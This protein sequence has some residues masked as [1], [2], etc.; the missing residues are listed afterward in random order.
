MP[1][2]CLA[3][4]ATLLVGAAAHAGP[5]IIYQPQN[6]DAT[7]MSTQ[8]QELFGQLEA[9]GMDELT[10]QWLRYGDQSF[11]GPDAW[12]PGAIQA[13]QRAGLRIR[14]GLFW[15]PDY[16][17][18]MS[19]KP[20]LDYVDDLLARNEALRVAAREQG[21]GQA[22]F[23]GWYLPLELSDRFGHNAEARQGIADRLTDFASRADASVAVSAYFTGHLAPATFARW[24]EKLRAGGLDVWVQDGYG[25]AL[26][27]ERAV[28]LYLDDLPC[29]VPIILEHFRRTSPLEEVFA[30][31]PATA[32]QRAQQGRDVG[33]HDKHSF[34]LRYHPAA[35]GILAH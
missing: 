25:A 12:L 4:V 5:G 18:R 10:I 1:G 31:R 22:R 28:P 2:R 19:P 23:A 17:Q 21:L 9:N 34:S 30:A 33:C 7:T 35:R 26:T 15:D 27:P 13:A 11:T 14:L 6:R 24:I 29:S 8:W 16:F 3:A 32:E 20:D